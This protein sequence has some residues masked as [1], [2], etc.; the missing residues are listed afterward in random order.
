MPVQTSAINTEALRSP[1]FRKAGFLP[2]WLQTS[3]PEATQAEINLLSNCRTELET[4]NTEVGPCKSEFMH[5]VVGGSKDDP[6]LVCL[7]GYGAGL[8]FYFRNL[9]GMC[10][11][12]RTHAVDWL[13]TGLSGR[14]PFK[15]SN[16]EETEDFFL[17][18]FETWRE[19][20]GLEKFVLMGHSMG[21][22]LAATYALKHPERV[23]HLVLVCPAAVGEKPDESKIPKWA[24][25]FWSWR[26][27]AWRTFSFLW[28]VGATPMMAIRGLGPWGR[29]M[30]GKYV[31][32]RF[33]QGNPFS[34]EEA[35]CME[36]YFYHITASKG[37]G[38]FAL[39][40]VMTPFAWGKAPLEH[41]LNELKVPVTFIYGEQDWMD[42]EA[43]ERTCKRIREAQGQPKND[44]D[45]SIELIPESGHFVFMDQP[46][47]FHR[48]L[49]KLRRAIS[50]Q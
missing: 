45:Q 44:C 2:R 4:V 39:R 1:A 28:N 48:E 32:N 18:P 19:K 10:S 23:E 36:D 42:P 13:G 17:K 35:S 11:L 21:G 27:Q 25:N 43:A 3:V 12:F 22:Y 47:L 50:P 9:D 20:N 31:N 46:E 24:E 8:G 7:P 14:P 15:A 33:N 49:A 26:G 29:D 16:R 6:S 38:E 40:H 34:K 41:R 5:S 30:I 37:S